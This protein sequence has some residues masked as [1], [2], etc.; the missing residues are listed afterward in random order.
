MAI[1]FALLAYKPFGSPPSD[2]YAL[3]LALVLVAVVILSAGFT[4]A[5]EV[6]S[7]A[8]VS[9][10]GRL[11]PP[12]CIV[13]RGGMPRRLPTSQLVVGDVVQ[14]GVGQRVP[15][16]MRVA[17]AAALQVDKSVLTGES[18]PVRVVAAPATPAQREPTGGGSV[19]GG[20]VSTSMLT[21]P[22]MVFMG[23]SVSVSARACAKQAAPRHRQ[24]VVS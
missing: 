5:Q 8:A 4:L 3:V 15:A 14:L 7:S 18:E 6:A 9:G 2:V 1:L 23:T 20:G 19:G 22:N 24:H 12:T 21:A 10:F 11:V 16:D 13:L 17:Q